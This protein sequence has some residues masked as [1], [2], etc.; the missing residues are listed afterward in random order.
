M[1]GRKKLEKL[2]LKLIEGGALFGDMLERRQIDA[3]LVI[4]TYIKEQFEN[5]ISASLG[6]VTYRHR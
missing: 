1:E 4:P 6:R 2:T 5:I 3:K